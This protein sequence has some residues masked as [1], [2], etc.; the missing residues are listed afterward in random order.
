MEKEQKLIGK[1]VLI[2][3]LSFD[4]KVIVEG[5]ATIKA[6]SSINK[7]II[8]S[9]YWADVIFEGDKGVYRRSFNKEQWII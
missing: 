2:K 8:P 5:V 4:G 7:N 1:K 9:I 6:I 3:N